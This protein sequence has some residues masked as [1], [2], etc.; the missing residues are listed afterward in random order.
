MSSSN[1]RA[2]QLL[3]SIRNKNLNVLCNNTGKVGLIEDVGRIRGALMFCERNVH[4]G[5]CCVA[6]GRLPKARS[7]AVPLLC[8]AS[9]ARREATLL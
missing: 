6:R 2:Q 3:I 9:H 5:L 4:E 8:G 7:M 1:S